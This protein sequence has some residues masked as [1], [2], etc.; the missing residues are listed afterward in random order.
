M[1]AAFEFIERNGTEL[2]GLVSAGKWRDSG[3]ARLRDIL[4]FWTGSPH[5]GK[6]QELTVNVFM[7]S[8]EPCVYHALRASTCG[9]AITIPWSCFWEDDVSE[10]AEVKEDDVVDGSETAMAQEDDVV[11][12][13][14][15]NG[16]E[17]E[18]SM[19]QERDVAEPAMVP[20]DVLARALFLAS[21]EESFGNA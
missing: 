15:Q 20:A 17:S 10:T 12:G 9:Y 14:G 8:D 19:I 16:S 4:S 13:P 3:D 6:A 11:G 21:M 2:Q 5:L 7:D 18:S 1:I